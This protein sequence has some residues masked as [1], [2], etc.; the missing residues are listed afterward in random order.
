MN[1]KSNETQEHAGEYT[2]FIEYDADE[3]NEDYSEFWKLK[4]E[5]TGQFICE[6]NHAMDGQKIMK[7]LCLLD[8][9]KQSLK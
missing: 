3:R 7:A 2:L 8:S 9:V 5:T 6:G 1:G 4:D